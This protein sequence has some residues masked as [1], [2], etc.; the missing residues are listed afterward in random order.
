MKWRICC[1]VPLLAKRVRSPV[2]H[3][4]DVDESKVVQIQIIRAEEYLGRYRMTG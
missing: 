3:E 2:L 4:E 1:S